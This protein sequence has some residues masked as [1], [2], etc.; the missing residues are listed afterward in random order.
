MT[1]PPPR[2]KQY[3][4][5]TVFSGH[6]GVK[7]MFSGRYGV[8]NG[9]NITQINRVHVTSLIDQHGKY[10]KRNVRARGCRA[11]TRGEKVNLRVN[12]TS[13]LGATGLRRTSGGRITPWPAGQVKCFL[14]AMGLKINR[15]HVPSPTVA[16][17]SSSTR[18][19]S[20]LILEV[21]WAL[22]G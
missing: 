16:A 3:P 9:R 5:K 11:L 12:F 22:R 19:R 6:Y 21:F 8:K 1:S 18:I 4:N 10:R 14:G 7:N 20:G 17:C 2:D 15:V 13:F